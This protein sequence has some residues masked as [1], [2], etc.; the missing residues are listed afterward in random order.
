MRYFIISN[1]TWD[2]SMPSP[3]AKVVLNR[4]C[5]SENS[6][7]SSSVTRRSATSTLAAQPLQ[8]PAVR[9]VS[10]IC[11]KATQGRRNTIQNV[12]EICHRHYLSSCVRE[13]IVSQTWLC[14]HQGCDS[15]CLCAFLLALGLESCCTD[16]K[17]FTLRKWDD[18][19]RLKNIPNPMLATIEL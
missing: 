4:D 7:T 14:T 10:E 13:M 18:D 2:G 3:A 1:L 17:R 15:N 19:T 8:D 6:S 11:Q 12:S 16:M 9:H 5:N